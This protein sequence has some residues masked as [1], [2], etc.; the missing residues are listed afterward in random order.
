LGHNAFA[1][2]LFLA[3]AYHSATAPFLYACKPT[4]LE[5]VNVLL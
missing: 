1:K 5:R 2:G 4:E 3:V